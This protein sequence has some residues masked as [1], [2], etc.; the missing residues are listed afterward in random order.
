M[1]GYIN[2]FKS[3]IRKELFKNLSTNSSSEERLSELFSI[4]NVKEY[5]EDLKKS[6]EEISRTKQL[7]SNIFKANKDY[8]DFMFIKLAFIKAKIEEEYRNFAVYKNGQEIDLDKLFQKVKQKLAYLKGFQNDIKFSFCDNFCTVDQID[9]REG[10]LEVNTKA[11][12]CTLP[13]SSKRKINII[14]AQIKNLSNGVPGNLSTGENRLLRNILNS[15]GSRFFEYNKLH[16]GPIKLVIEFDFREER[17]INSFILKQKSQMSAANLKVE[18][19]FYRSET[20]DVVELNKLVNMQEQNLVCESFDIEDQIK[21]LHLP[22]KA[23]KAEI[24]LKSDEY[25][26][27]DGKKYFNISL[28]E[29]IFEQIKYADEGSLSFN[30]I[31]IS[32]KN[33][34]LM[35]SDHITHPPISDKSLVLKTEAEFG[36]GETFDLSDEVLILKGSERDVRLKVK[37][38]RTNELNNLQIV[39]DDFTFAESVCK[40]QVFDRRQIPGRVTVDYNEEGLEIYQP[41][42]YRRSWNPRRGLTLGRLSEEV[43]KFYFPINLNDLNIDY[44]DVKIYINRELY[45]ENSNGNLIAGEYEIDQSGDFILIKSN[46]FDNKPKVNVLLDPKYGLIKKTSSSLYIR[47]KEEFDKDTS[48]I[49]IKNID[50]SNKSAND[51]AAY[52]DTNLINL[53][54]KNIASIEVG[55]LD[56]DEYTV[57]YINGTIKSTVTERNISVRYQYYSETIVEDIKLWATGEKC[58]GVFIPEEEIGFSKIN[59]TLSDSVEVDHLYGNTKS[60]TTQRANAHVLK[61]PGI[62]EGSVEV[63]KDLFGTEPFIEIRPYI[64]GNKEFLGL[65]HIKDLIPNIE[66]NVAGNINFTLSKEPYEGIE[67]F[68]FYKDNVEVDLNGE[69]NGRICTLAIGGGNN[70]KGYSVEYVCSEDEYPGFNKYSIDYETGILYTSSN[71]SADKEISYEISNIG[72]EYDIVHPVKNWSAENN[73][74]EFNPNETLTTG[75]NSFIKIAWYKNLDTFNIEDMAEYYSPL[76]Y[77][78]K[79]EMS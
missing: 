12:V 4:Q 52:L 64:D 47:I 24:H 14:D 44:K 31:D 49:R 28:K 22:A 53:P 29:V 50:L 61:Y 2:S 21:I 66:A 77:K 15:S 75:R 55:G 6:L 36:G 25:I 42:I 17:I 33:L 48:N 10:N 71:I 37:L 9:S 57:D 56:S 40:Q 41:E 30:A 23:R 60:R 72:I 45:T 11:E 69:L 26:V 27:L 34:Y 18:N 19:I 1:Q 58:L 8:I 54:H 73:I 63:D 74:V 62:I 43:S 39:E 46:T 59:Q 76:L 16:T 32:N 20:G 68:K 78:A 51:Y 7:D 67:K 38:K 65:K 5:E 3:T 13:I 79:V 35:K 70:S